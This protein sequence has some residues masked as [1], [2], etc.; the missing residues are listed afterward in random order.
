MLI[1]RMKDADVEPVSALA[2]VN[3]GGVMAEYHSAEVLARFRGDV[4]PDA[5]REQMGWKQVFVVE[6]EGEV[7]A[8]GALADFGTPEKP[9]CTVSQFYVRPDRHRQ[10]IGDRLLAHLVVAATEGGAATIHVPSSR[11]AIPFYEHAGFQMDA[12]QPNAATEITWMTL[13]LAERSSGWA[14]REE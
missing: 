1:R 6:D 9:K 10:G 4:T 5:F 8:T 2:Q 7:I 12:A 3:Y 13:P 14:D 11:N